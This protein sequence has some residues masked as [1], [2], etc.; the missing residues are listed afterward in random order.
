MSGYDKRAVLRQNP[1]FAG[2]SA[3]VIDRL[4][5]YAHTKSFKAGSTIF[6][7][8]DPGTGL[9]AVCSGTV[10]ISNHSHDG[11][12]AVF[13]LI[14]PGEI[15]GEIALLDGRPRTAEA[16]ALSDC[17]LM[18]IDRRDF[19]PL[20]KS[21][22]DIALK[23]IDVLCARLRHTSKQ[24]EDV[25]FLDLP[26]RLAKTLLRLAQPSKSSA[27]ESKVTITQKEIGQIIGMSRES[28]NKQLREWEQHRWVKLERGGVVVLAAQKLQDIAASDPF[29]SE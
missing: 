25:L 6:A 7:K 15:F 5:S 24:V 28:T 26:G 1:L 12:D 2:L 8:G 20:V 11:K 27:Q 13:N 3:D 10:K 22:P 9:F 14:S 17:E 21:Q 4:A 23:L 19:V 16:L 29:D 18:L